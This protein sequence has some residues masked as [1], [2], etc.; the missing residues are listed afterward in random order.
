MRQLVKL[1]LLCETASLYAQL[2]YTTSWIGNSFS[3]KTK[4]V[5]QD[6]TDIFIAPDGTAYSNVFWD[7]NGG[8]VT[9]YKDGTIIKTA[10]DT[11]G[12]GYH[13]GDAVTANSKYLYFGYFVENEGGG[14]VDQYRWP[15][16]GYDWYCVTRRK[17]SNIQS[18]APWDGGKGGKTR[19]HYLLIHELPNNTPGAHISGLAA[20]DSLLFISCPYDDKIRTYD[21]ETMQLVREWTLKNPGRLTLDSEGMLWA[22]S[23]RTAFRFDRNGNK[24]AQKIEFETDFVPYDIDAT[25]DD[26]LFVSDRGANQN[27]RIYE[28][29]TSAPTFSDTFGEQF[30][31]YA[32]PVVGEFGDLRFNNPMGVGVDNSGNIYVASS[33]S[34]AGE[35]G[36]G[37]GVVLESYTA[38]GILNWRLFGLEFVDCADVD[39]S[40]DM[41]V[42]TKEE[43]FILDYSKPTGEQWTYKG[44]TVN[45]YKYPD[46]PRLHNWS[47]GAKV[48]R[49]QG[50]LFLFINTMHMETLFQCCRFSPETDG[51]IAVPSVFFAGGP[52]NK[53][54]GWPNGQPA[55]GEYIWC[56]ANGDG[57]FQADEY[58]TRGG[59]G[60]PT[61]WG[62]SVDSDGTVWQATQSS[63]IRKFPLQKLDEHGNPI[64]TFDSMEMID[65]PSPINRLERIYYVPEQD[66]MYLVGYTQDNPHH[67]GMWKVMGREV[68]RYDNWNQGNRIARWRVVP[69]YQQDNSGDKKP[70]SVAIAA[71]FL[72]IVYVKEERVVVYSTET[73]AFVGELS[74]VQALGDCGWVDIPEG[75]EAHKRVSGEYVVFV[76]EDAKAK[77][78]MYQWNPVGVDIGQAPK[79]KILNPSPDSLYSMPVSFIVQAGATD[80]GSVT[81]VEFFADGQKLGKDTD[82]SDGWTTD[83]VNV[84][85]GK[86]MLLARATDNDGL[87]NTSD[88]VTIEVIVNDGPF[89]G[90]PL[91][92]PARIEAEHFDGGG[93]GVGYHDS[94]TE[95][96][97]GEFRSEG[98]DIKKCN[99]LN[100]G[101]CVFNIQD[102]EW[103]AYTV[104]VEIAALYRL[105]IRVAV[106]RDGGQFSMKLNEADITGT[107][108]IP[109]TS[110][111]GSW[112][113]I[114]IDSLKLPAG[115]ALLT[116]EAVTG[117]F[118][119]N[120]IDVL[121]AGTG[122]ITREWWS[123]APGTRI[124]DIPTYRKPAGSVEINKF[125]CPINWAD[126]YGQR[127]RGYLYPPATGDYTF[128]IASDDA[129]ELRLSSDAF[130]FNKKRLCGVS[131]WTPSRAWDNNP[132]Q[133]SKSI[134]LQAGRKCYIEALHK[135]GGGGDNLAVAWQGPGI[136]RGVI[137]G[138]FLSPYENEFPDLLIS[139]ISWTP[140]KPQPGEPITFAAEITNA[141]DKAIAENSGVRL[142][143]YLGDSL[144]TQTEIIQ[145]KIA[146]WGSKILR[147]EKSVI[148]NE[149]TFDITARIDPENHLDESDE[150]NNHKTATIYIGSRDPDNPD[151][152]IPGMYYEYYHGAWSQLPDFDSLNPIATGACKNFDIALR[153]RDDEFAF[154]FIGYISVP[155]MGDYTFYTASD[156]GS[157]LYIGDIEIV[158]NDGA[159]GVEEKS[160]SMPLKAGKHAIAVTFFEAGGGEELTVSYKGPS[161]AKQRIP[162]NM[163]YVS[164]TLAQ[165]GDDQSISPK[166][167]MLYP[168]APNPFNPGTQIRFDL[169]KTAHVSLRIYN[170]L[171]QR[172]RFLLDEPR[173][174]GRYILTWDGL[175]DAGLQVSSGV[176]FLTVQSEDFVAT[177]KIAL[178]R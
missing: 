22:M 79:V 169:P 7:E 53:P 55:Q 48:Q 29:I 160:G 130:P 91:Q 125:E 77:I 101:F 131:G 27:I 13:G 25:S 139:T 45:K 155:E 26:R 128:W 118:E 145:E 68:A 20:D 124:A 36:G 39:P 112:Q 34:S 24:L 40:S 19:G 86:H 164:K 62:W 158:N 140:A 9:Q 153:K 149:G 16:K 138:Q 137:D 33:N 8:E 178:V 98:V 105:K 6:I 154:R 31:I 102:G 97:G 35:T 92:L 60:A 61:I 144:L 47:A 111:P 141:S 173:D 170:V 2:N 121:N 32:G 133:K 42:Y 115:V 75:I 82:G 41:D 127:V 106:E 80:D 54:D 147:A 104:D 171:G 38:D 110:G 99:D 119:L 96:T 117:G 142:E 134:T 1:L 72:F 95:N 14:L 89:F 107:V 136:R 21:A 175:D 90:E 114:T 159:H 63:G 49:I 93:E 70:A 78:I 150:I 59:L 85:P 71:E 161:I 43:H 156:D 44:Y 69:D 50:E 126:D 11:H 74:P 10:Q 30:G 165:V 176:Y 88:I 174:A 123:N 116:F 17:L 143:F 37:G 135:E 46:D 83:W 64:W 18:K 65:T 94:D 56:D 3:G 109:T 157:K 146:P 120:Y 122:S 151:D 172:V 108:N 4:W 12:W 168:N 73:G 84:I 66:A 152:V 113:T 163:L 100:N 81:M 148:F 87:S 58:A 67:D 15:P 23:A 28:N 162:D 57:A 129:S 167:F 51:E 166:D 177:K 132:E 52:H 76:E 103:L 5:Q